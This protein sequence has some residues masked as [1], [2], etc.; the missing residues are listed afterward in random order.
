M[1]KLIFL[2]MILSCT[3]CELFIEEPHILAPT[4]QATVSP[5]TIDYRGSSTITWSSENSEYVLLNG[6]E[7][8]TEGSLVL[9]GLTS[10]TNY[11]I[12]A[13]GKDGKTVEKTLTIV[14]GKAEAPTVEVTV[15][16]DTVP[17][18]QSTTFYWVASGL[19]TGVTLDG[20]EVANSGS[21][22]TPNLYENKAYELVVTGPGGVVKETVTILVAEK[23]VSN[24]DLI[25]GEPWLLK[26]IRCIRNGEIIFNGVLSDEDKTNLSYYSLDGTSTV[27]HSDGRIF[28]GFNWRFIDSKYILE[29]D[30]VYSFKLSYYEYVRSQEV[31]YDGQPATYEVTYY[32][33]KKIASN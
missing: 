18:G 13:V 11:K 30:I 32:R 6:E 3:G 5:E 1:K 15:S 21:F 31:L 16:T 9:H 14:V 2:F 8:E 10:A 33:V 23:T 7:V 26:S 4:L 25:T 12:V 19:V 17:Y 20:N 29:G 22:T 28:C 27:R 24:T